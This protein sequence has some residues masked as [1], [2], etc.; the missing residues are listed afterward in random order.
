[1]MRRTRWACLALLAALWLFAAGS[2]LAEERYGTV[3]AQSGAP[4]RRE[5]FTAAASLGHYARGTWM[6][7]TGESKGWYAVT[8]PDGT[9]GYMLTRDITVPSVS[10]VNV[11]IVSNLRETAYVNLRRNPHYQADV[12]ATY[13]NGTPCLLLSHSDGWYHVRAE[14]TEGYLR[15]EYVQPQ[16]MVWAEETATV[17]AQ[18]GA[19]ADLRAGPGAGYASL[20]QYPSGQYVMVIQRGTGWWYVSVDGRTGF[21]DAA[22]L[23]EGILTFAEMSDV[24]WPV[25]SGAWAVVSNPTPTQLLNL[26]ETPSRLGNVLG[27]FRSGTRMTLLNQGLEWCRVMTD[28]GEVGYMMTEYLDLEGVPDVPVMTVQHPDETYVN[29]R[30]APSMT[31]GTV[32]MQVPHGTQVTVLIPGIDWMK[33][34]CGETTGYMSAWFLAE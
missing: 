28:K 5:P 8:A 22:V 18:G 7:V 27:Q 29:L 33:V 2:A 26:R 17:I 4:M 16:R 25:L 10:V 32:Q 21:M 30:S 3:S 1:M 6:T 19:A 24:G 9:A 13:H 11:G 12:L 15:E 31:L 14:G 34:Q 23:R 20:G